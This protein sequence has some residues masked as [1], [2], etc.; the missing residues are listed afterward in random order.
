MRNSRN[1]LRNPGVI[2][3]SSLDEIVPVER[4]GGGPSA[5]VATRRLQNFNI[6]A[7]HQPKVSRCSLS[8]KVG[9]ALVYLI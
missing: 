2:T 1:K 5:V 7:R 3:F 9:I 4:Y 8:H 6:A